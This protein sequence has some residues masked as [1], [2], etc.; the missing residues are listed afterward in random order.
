MTVLMVY[1]VQV[2][3]QVFIFNLHCKYYPQKHI[4]NSAIIMSLMN[5]GLMHVG[6][7]QSAIFSS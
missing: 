5:Y 2:H 3:N 1:F 7:E 6:G 4:F